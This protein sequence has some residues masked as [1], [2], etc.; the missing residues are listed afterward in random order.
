[1][2]AQKF[3]LILLVLL[4]VVGSSFAQA[5]PPP[6]RDGDGVPDSRD[7]CISDVGP[8][9]NNGCPETSTA[10]RATDVPPPDTAGDG[11]ADPLD[12]CPNEAGDGANGGCPANSTNN[13][14]SPAVTPELQLADPT[15]GDC[16]VSTQGSSPV[17]IRQYPN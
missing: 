11:T 6:D 7:N 14:S 12:R 1:M 16:V 10:P 8:A 17:N 13:A 9:S 15:T 3:L 4:T 5:A 2:Q